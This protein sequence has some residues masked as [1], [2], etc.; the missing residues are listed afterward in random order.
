M[1]YEFLILIRM[2]FPAS[3]LKFKSISKKYFAYIFVKIVIFII[4]FFNKI[5]SM[6]ILLL[7]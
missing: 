3:L 2:Y 4:F 5:I 1:S 6:S 7:S